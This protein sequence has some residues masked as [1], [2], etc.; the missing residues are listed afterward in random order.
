MVSQHGPIAQMLTSENIQRFGNKLFHVNGR[1]SALDL[2]S[3]SEPRDVV[4]RVH[5]K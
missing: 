1:N 5:L 3:P 4:S 2:Q